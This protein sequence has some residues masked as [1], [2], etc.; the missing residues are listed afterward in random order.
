MVQVGHLRPFPPFITRIPTY[1]L[2]PGAGGGSGAYRLPAAGD[3]S[4]TIQLYDEDGRIL[5]VVSATLVRSPESP[6]DGE[7]EQGGFHGT[8][9]VIATDGGPVAAAQVLGKWIRE[10]DG[11]GSIGADILVPESE[12]RD[13]RLVAVGALRAALRTGVPRG[14]ASGTDGL[15]ARATIG[16]ARVSA[17]WIVQP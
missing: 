2:T 3:G 11:T 7:A 15:R 8:L 16:L 14:G 12:D 10:A 6:P 9:F 17:S 13:H 5:Y 1:A 4:A